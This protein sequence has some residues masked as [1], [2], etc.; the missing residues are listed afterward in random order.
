[1]KKYLVIMA[2][3]ALATS[4]FAQGTISMGNL[5]STLVKQ[6]TAKGDSTLISAPVASAQV[7]FLAAP[8]GTSLTPLGTL[9][10]GGF[11]ASFS[12]LAGFLAAN[13]GW[14]AYTTTGISPVAGRFGGGVV[15][16]N[17]AAHGGIAAGGNIEYIVIGWQGATG[18]TLDSA[19][20]LGSS[21]IGQ[22]AL[23][24]GVATGNPTT[25]PA[26]TP[27][28]MNAT[29]GGLTLAPLSV[30]PEPSTF[31]LAGL[32]AAALLAFRRRK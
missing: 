25:I 13:P 30:V 1:M 28:L 10:A 23:V 11:S 3:T 4:V 15:T 6:W 32:G 21:F 27:S 2:A 19:L 18:S 14:A 24:A 9:G 26:G 12:T 7:Q 20:A 29:F 16:I 17:D 8:T 5:S 31:A 22:S